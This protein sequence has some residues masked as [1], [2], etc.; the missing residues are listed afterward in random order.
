MG[1]RLQAGHSRIGEVFF[2]IGEGSGTVRG[3]SGINACMQGGQPVSCR[4]T[5]AAPAAA[6]PTLAVSSCQPLCR[7]VNIFAPQAKS[8]RRARF[9]GSVTLTTCPSRLV[10][11]AYFLIGP[12]NNR[13]GATAAVGVNAGCKTAG[14]GLGC[15]RSAALPLVHMHPAPVRAASVPPP[16]RACC[17]LRC[18]CCARCGSAWAATRRRFTRCEGRGALGASDA[19]SGCA[20]CTH[21][22]RCAA[23]PSPAAAPCGALP[24]PRFPQAFEFDSAQSAS[25]LA[26]NH[27]E[28]W[29][30][31]GPARLDVPQP[32][33]GLQ[34][35]RHYE[36]V[37]LYATHAQLGD[38]CGMPSLCWKLL[39]PTVD[40]PNLTPPSDPG[41]TEEEIAKVERGEKLP[42][43][44]HAH[45][46][47]YASTTGGCSLGACSVAAAPPPLHVA[48]PCVAPP[49][50]ST[51]CVAA[52][53]PCWLPHGP[54]RIHNWFT[55]FAALR[56][57][58]PCSPT[59]PMADI[60]HPSASSA[61]MC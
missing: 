22:H 17:L 31:G 37:C 8:S 59:Q 51:A 38:A 49:S 10:R 47:G 44:L 24:L 43:R 14:N 55:L 29:G 1:G 3:E 35:S 52:V 11:V 15:W 60:H 39:L 6:P 45:A 5:A 23:A 34:L 30:R 53:Q 33:L 36:I 13:L 19:A 56:R 4:A 7:S 32:L 27:C 50:F 28:L 54:P 26:W 20:C 25:F 42:P 46:D 2:F 58:G 18:R 40:T 9:A 12:I 61:A 41:L 57:R 16:L 21:P 48:P